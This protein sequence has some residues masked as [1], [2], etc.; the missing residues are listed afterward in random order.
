MANEVDPKAAQ[1]FAESMKAAGAAA[2]EAMGAFEKQARVV[3]QM[4]DAM[5]EVAKVMYAL[6]QQDCKALNPDVWKNVTKEVLK[7]QDAMKKQADAGKKVNKTFKEVS[8]TSAKLA[9]GLLFTGNVLSGLAQGMRNLVAI[10]RTAFN[11]ITSIADGFYEVGKSI[12]S[13][14]FKMLKGLYSMA[15]KGGDNSVRTELENIRENYGD[16]AGI[17]SRTVV[18]MAKSLDKFSFSGAT[19]TRVF[20][21]FAERLKASREFADSLSTSFDHFQQELTDPAASEALMRYQRALSFTAEQQGILANLAMKNNTSLEKGYNDLGKQVLGMS[22]AFNITSKIF[23]KEL[24]KAVQDLAHFG[25]L[26]KTELAASVAYTTK[27]GLSVEKLQGLMDQTKSYESTVENFSVINET[28]NTTID[29]MKLM[30]FKS[31]GEKLDYLRKKFAETGKDMTNMSRAETD[32]LKA[33]LN[34]DDAT[35]NTIFSTKNQGVTMEKVKTQADRNAEAMLSQA[36]AMKALAV[37][38]KQLTPAGNALAGGV[39][40][41]LLEGFLRGIQGSKEFIGMMN[42]IRTVLREATQYGVQLGRKFVQMFP[43]VSQ[44]FEGIKDLFNPARFRRMF[45]GVLDAFDFFTKTGSSNVEGFMEHLSKVFTNFLGEGKG[46]TTK[47]LDGFKK[48]GKALFAIM[49]GIGSWL[50]KKIQEMY[51]DAVKEIENPGPTSKAVMGHISSVIADLSKFI[52]EKATPFLV[53]GI[54]MLTS[55]L[56][57]EEIAKAAPVSKLRESLGKIFGPLGEALSK[58]WEELYPVLKKLVAALIVKIKDFF[59]SSWSEMD[60]K[61][62]LLAVGTVVGPVFRDIVGG[63]IKARLIEK[64]GQKLIVEGIEKAVTQAVASQA[65]ASAAA[66]AA[67]TAATAAG[68]AAVEGAVAASAATA[69]AGAAAASGTGGVLATAATAIGG[70]LSLPVVAGAAIVAGVVGGSLYLMNQSVKEE[71]E[72]AAAKNTQAVIDAAKDENKSLL[73]RF[74]ALNKEQQEVVQ[75]LNDERG[76]GLFES[77]VEKQYKARLSQIEAAQAPLEAQLKVQRKK[78]REDAA[79]LLEEKRKKDLVEKQLQELGPINFEN[80]EQKFKK[81][82]ELAKKIMGK[83]FDIDA[84]LKEV[85]DKLSSINFSIIDPEKDK[86][87]NESFLQ[88][89][90]I[91]KIFASAKSITDAIKL[92][93]SE[94]AKFDPG[95]VQEN[96]VKLKSVIRDAIQSMTLTGTGIEV[97]H[98]LSLTEV[99]VPKMVNMFSGMKDISAALKTYLDNMRPITSRSVIDNNAILNTA[100]G[101]TFTSFSDPAF[102]TNLDKASENGPKINVVFSSLRN[103]AESLK[104]F[105]ADMKPVGKDSVTT[106]LGIMQHAVWLSMYSLTQSPDAKPLDTEKLKTLPGIIED[107]DK[108]FSRMKGAASSISDFN[109]EASKKNI[110]GIKDAVVGN[111]KAIG[112]I[113]AATQVLE[114]SLNSI[115]NIDIGGKLSSLASGLG[116]GGNFSYEVKKKDVVVHLQVNVTMDTT[117]LEGVIIS[118]RKSI[119]RDRLN[120]SMS[121][122]RTPDQKDAGRLGLDRSQYTLRAADLEGTN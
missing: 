80:A 37:E 71:A 76:W 64:A 33:H 104:G 23:S 99:W 58:A 36:D 13:I 91:E 50:F 109:K 113:V 48:F 49:T 122:E 115:P 6:C 42:N 108:M 31:Q 60:W 120:L 70:A 92:I 81:I 46:P 16:L 11:I 118:Q 34:L 8:T 59:V 10:G 100:I 3:G 5:E 114:N 7:N 66:S 87:L 12:I 106:N 27:L 112:E 14:P 29:Y 17:S 73:E 90:K 15:A 85:R 2:E 18:G 41:H 82:S 110:S 9:K 61:Q 77:D 93:K 52:R 75:K 94:V 89:Q 57:G 40:D 116:M 44:V 117:E 20:G 1:Q 83:D 38:I 95:S 78:Q 84:K 103:I 63:A 69:T 39:F 111:I 54:T 21:N 88:F 79:K 26:T 68:T 67:S 102:M 55:W 119:I 19:A 62:Q 25:H 35:I 53:E 4:R 107:V 22:K 24:G 86:E 43:G 121:S 74:G 97:G 96:F 105:L 32:L 45:K 56:K 28:F 30:N 51:H 65:A 47:I 98:D 72:R 101:E